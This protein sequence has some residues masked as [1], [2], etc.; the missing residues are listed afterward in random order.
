MDEKY[1]RRKLKKLRALEEK[2]SYSN[3]KQTAK[4]TAK[5]VK[6]KTDFFSA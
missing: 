2:L 6:I 4:L 5:I 3:P 1:L